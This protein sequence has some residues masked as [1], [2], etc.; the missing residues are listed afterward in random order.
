MATCLGRQV[1][2]TILYMDLKNVFANNKE[3]V[4]EKLSLDSEYFTR[5]SKVQNPEIL[6]IGCSD[7]RVPPEDIMGLSC[8]EA[9]VYRNIANVVPN[10]DLSSMS[11]IHYAV[12]HLKVNHI[13]VCGHYYCGAVEAAIKL[14]DLGVLNPWLKN[15]RD[16]Y[17][18]HKEELNSITDEENRYKRLVELN[19]LE[20]CVNV[21]KTS[22]V[23]L[24][25]RDREIAVH[26]WV[27]DIQ[28]G[29]LID[30]KI[31]FLSILKKVQE[32]YRFE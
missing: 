23:Q 9:F 1:I 2:L 15:I 17:L 32:I 26:G 21:I 3:W 30:L 22:E 8:G 29:L 28:S 16:V 14:T 10:S 7:S 27:Y 4:Q 6:Y 13:V 24:A 20:Q 11:A 31:D 18:L 12:S 5:L 19:V 25:Y